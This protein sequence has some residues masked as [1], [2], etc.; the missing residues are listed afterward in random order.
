MNPIYRLNDPSNVFSPALLFY[1]DLIRRNIAR[2]I[3]IAGSPDRLR[4]HAKTHKTREITRMLLAAGVTK[5]KCATI[6]E[7][8]ML[9][10]TEAPDVLIAFQMVGPN[11]QRVARLA[12]KFPRTR[13]GVTVDHPLPLKELAAAVSSAGQSIDVY[14]D[15]NC[16]MNRTGIAP[17]TDARDLYGQI[18]ASPGLRPAGFHVYDGHNT[19]ESLDERTKAVKALL[20]PV[21]ALRDEL[22]RSGVPVPGMIM[23]GTPTFSIHAKLNFP[24]V[25]C[26]PGTLALH[27]HNY[28][29]RYPE[30]DIT[31]AAILLTRIISKPTADRLT[32][33][34]GS[35]SVS[36]DQPAGKRCVLLNVSNY[37]PILQSEEHLVIRTPDAASFNPGDVIY[38]MP[39]HVCTT[40]A[41]HRQALVVDRGQVVERWNIVGRDRE[42]TI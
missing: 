24:G 19:Q 41:L 16:G 34:L 37:E 35:K 40:V 25:E 9:A 12:A 18:A 21:L 6:A 28:V 39:A 33:D 30:L 26:S 27:D 36:P 14:M 4:P 20:E 23:G 7:A 32:L 5:H 22:Q 10:S 8:E 13:F 11:C 17:G 15:I 1:R 3:E 42:L 2:A 38:A 29:S 31:P